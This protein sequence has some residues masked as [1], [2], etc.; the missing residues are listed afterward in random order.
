MAALGQEQ[1]QPQ[2]AQDFLTMATQNI[3]AAVQIMA[4]SMQTAA[5]MAQAVQQVQ[6][7]L[8]QGTPQPSSLDAASGGLASD[9]QASAVD[10][11]VSY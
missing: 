10:R 8:G 6:T 7:M 9:M 4:G 5:A 2:T 11:G 3:Q 1:L